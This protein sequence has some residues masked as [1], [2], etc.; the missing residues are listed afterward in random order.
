MIDTTALVVGTGF[1]GLGMAMELVRAGRRDFVVLERAD[2]VGGVWR[3]NTYP[4]AGC[5]V[6]SPYYSYSYAPN[7]TWPMR[8]ALQAD[9]KAYLAKLVDDY[10]LREHLRFGAAVASAVFDDATGR[11]TVR[12][13]NGDEYS[14]AVFVPATGQ[15][16]RP[17][18]PDIP[19]RDSFDGPAFHSACWDHDVPLAGRRVAVIGTG[20]S[21]VQFVPFVVA[22]AAAVTLFQRSAPYVLPKPDATYHPRHQKLFRTVPPLL[23]LERFG[24]WL[25]L[26][27]GMLGVTGNR[28]VTAIA[29]GVSAVHRR[30][31][32]PDRALRATLTPDYPVGCKRVLFADDYYPALRESHVRVETARITEITPYGP[33]TADGVVHEADVM[34][35]GTG[36]ATQDYLAPIE[37]TGAGGVEL[38][39]VWADGPFAYLGMA[40]PGFPN[41]FLMYGPN[42]NLGS[43]S[44]VYMLERQA[45]YIRR[46]VEHLDRT[47]GSTVDVKP[48]VA[49]LFDA[50][51]QSRLAGT[52]WTGCDS[53]YRDENGRITNNWPGLV[54]EYHRRTRRFDPADYRAGRV[55]P[56]GA[57]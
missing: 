43:G 38:A 26:E 55:E 1:G 28:L 37:I 50:E 14:A 53:W 8:F 7:P 24:W 56:V 48:A 49:A 57:S 31:Q 19:G 17:S 2:E 36:F 27:L 9:I 4:G 12:T 25:M 42:T 44:I 33:R 40:V 34:I 32:V 23:T 54:T 20:A 15:L 35:Y 10:G 3:E 6:P 39:D 29:R 22:D 41:M 30:R 18:I 16:S 45:R 52:A 11:W 5:D 46:V 13:T 51:I 21:A 47:T